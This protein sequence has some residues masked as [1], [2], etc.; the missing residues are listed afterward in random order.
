MNK[1]LILLMLLTVLGVSCSA[2][3]EATGLSFGL[4]ENFNG[5]SVQVSVFPN[6]KTDI[7]AVS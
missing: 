7:E 3:A 2:K 6:L 4:I 5:E 1:Q